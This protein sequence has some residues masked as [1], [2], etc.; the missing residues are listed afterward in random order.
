MHTTPYPDSRTVLVS[1]G[2]RGIGRAIVEHLATLGW[3]LAFTY[4]SEAAR[5]QALVHELQA[6]ARPGQR[7]AAYAVDLADDDAVQAL[8]G[9][10]VTDFG[11]LDALVNNAGLTDDGAFLAMEPA[12]WQ[13][14]LRANFGGT[15][16]L[17]LAALRH[18]L[19][20]R[21]PAVVIV[22]SL[23][24]LSGKEGQVSYATSKGALVGFTQ[25]LG[26]RYGARGLRV[27]AIAPGFI[28]TEMVDALEP[29]MYEHIVHGTA[30]QRMGEAEEVARA[31]AFL[32]APG[33]LQ[34]TTLR[35]DGGFK[36]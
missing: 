14:V 24:G 4:R 23:A 5:A 30:L 2:T 36:R 33:Y 18:L 31:V 1:G 27:N 6:R 16:R 28:R 21:E 32:L 25:W 20:G 17:T 15:A 8:P 7:I 3:N 34:S 35:V 29:Q 10:V 11:G 22:A 26:R 13:R 12:R 19:Q 9:R